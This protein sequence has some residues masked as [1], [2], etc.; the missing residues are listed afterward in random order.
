MTTSQCI[1]PYKCNLWMSLLLRQL[2]LGWESIV[3]CKPIKYKL[4]DCKKTI[5]L[6]TYTTVCKESPTVMVC[7]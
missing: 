1:I 3:N 4:I 7:S 5:N 2:F 6:L